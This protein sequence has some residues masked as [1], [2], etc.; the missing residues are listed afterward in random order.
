MCARARPRERERCCRAPSHRRAGSNLRRQPRGMFRSRNTLGGGSSLGPRTEASFTRSA[1]RE[2][3]RPARPSRVERV[4]ASQERNHVAR[5][6]DSKLCWTPAPTRPGPAR[7][8]AARRGSARS[9]APNSWHSDARAHTPRHTRQ[10]LVRV[11]LAAASFR[12]HPFA[13]VRGGKCW[14]RDA[15]GTTNDNKQRQ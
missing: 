15:A 4:A 10:T 1:G 3:Q 6:R 14:S 13:D 7:P 5:A 11:R 9:R 12:S 2:P 8:V